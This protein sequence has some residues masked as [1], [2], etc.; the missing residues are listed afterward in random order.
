MLPQGSKDGSAPGR[1]RQPERARP[2]CGRMQDEEEKDPN[3]TTTILIMLL[4]ACRLA[5]AAWPWPA[6]S[7]PDIKVLRALASAVPHAQPERGAHGREGRCQCPGGGRGAEAR[8]AWHRGHAAARPGLRPQEPPQAQAVPVV[9]DRHGRGA[10]LRPGR[11][12][13][14]RGLRLDSEAR[15]RSAPGRL[16]EVRPDVEIEAQLLQPPGGVAN[17]HSDLARRLVLLDACRRAASID[18]TVVKAVVEAG[19]EVVGKLPPLVDDILLRASLPLGEQLLRL[20]PPPRRKK[21]GRLRLNLRHARIQ[22]V[23]RLRHR[24]DHDL[25]HVLV[26]QLHPVGD[27]VKGPP[28]AAALKLEEAAAAVV[29]GL[30]ARPRGVR[31]EGHENRARRGVARV[32][33]DRGR[34]GPGRLPGPALDHDRIRG[35]GD[36]DGPGVLAVHR[37]HAA[38]ALKAVWVPEGPG[39]GAVAHVELRALVVVAVQVHEGPVAHRHV[40]FH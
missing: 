37:V 12:S 32:P 25:R 20:L 21:R 36:G 1:I 7:L 26:V 10:Q 11:A 13:G 18:A 22:R 5:G 30:T 14:V 29:V 3:A 34:P 6:A 31:V 9:V 17:G 27:E 40:D 24:G 15:R 39:E 28:G 35:P 38:P 8:V 33:R 16:H 23:L 2:S 19:D 4:Q